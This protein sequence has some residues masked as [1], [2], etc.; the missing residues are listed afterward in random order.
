MGRGEPRRRLGRWRRRLGRW[1]RWWSG[2]GGGGPWGG[3]RS[4]GGGGGDAAKSPHREPA[5]AG[6]G[7]A[8]RRD[9]L[10][11]GTGKED[12]DGGSSQAGADTRSEEKAARAMSKGFDGGK[13][14]IAGEAMR[15]TSTEGRWRGRRRRGRARAARKGEGDGAG[16]GAGA[17]TGDGGGEGDGRRRRWG[18][19]G[20]ATGIVE[21]STMREESDR[22]RDRAA[23]LGYKPNVFSFATCLQLRLIDYC[24]AQPF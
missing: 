9:S 18:W 23:Q 22:D 8:T 24:K 21:N 20:M 6:E 7:A 12:G 4:S 5:E 16:G 15:R 1:R 2:E 19:R 3:E 10:E 13:P 11:K 17:R 14:P